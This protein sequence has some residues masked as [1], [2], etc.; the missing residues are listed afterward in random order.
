MIFENIPIYMK[1]LKTKFNKANK[2]RAKVDI[3]C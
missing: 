2:N 3:M 1:R